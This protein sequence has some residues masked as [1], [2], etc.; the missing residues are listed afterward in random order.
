MKLFQKLIHSLGFRSFSGH[1]IFLSP[2][3]SPPVVLD[4]GTNRGVFLGRF[5]Q[6]LGDVGETICVEAN[7]ELAQCLRETLP[8]AR[9]VIHAAVVGTSEEFV[10][11]HLSDNIEA[12]SLYSNVSDVY[13][14]IRSVRVPCV[15]LTG[16]LRQFD[17]LV[18]DVVKLDIEGAETDVLLAIQKQDVSNVRQISVE[19]HDCFSAEMR[20]AVNEVRKRMKEFGF[21]EVNANW[22]HTD[23]ILFVNTLRDELTTIPMRFRIVL[24]KLAFVLR[25]IL[26]QLAR[27]VGLR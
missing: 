23:D 21:R 7:P 9:R 10:E 11:L 6:F 16:I 4:C 24:V 17:S 22:P 5:T 27:N 8:A 13:G 1:T 18:V 14:T 25:G 15:T 2:I 19:F 3:A 20:P 26:L 12:S